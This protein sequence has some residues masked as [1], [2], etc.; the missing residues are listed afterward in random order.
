MFAAAAVLT[1]LISGRP[2]PQP[3]SKLLPEVRREIFLLALRS[4][5][6]F[7]LRV[8]YPNRHGWTVDVRILDN[9]ADIITVSVAPQDEPDD[10]LAR[11]RGTYDARDDPDREARH[12]AQA[13]GS[14]A[15][16]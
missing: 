13:L 11:A 15:P 14:K 3:Q 9:T 8:M 16:P 10:I 2:R 7:W 12:I 6:R 5:V 1:L 4:D